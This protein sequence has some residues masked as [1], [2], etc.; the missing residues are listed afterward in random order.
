MN[1]G[2][3][4]GPYEVVGSLGAGG[5]G[6]VCRARDTRLNRDVALKVLPEAF[7]T[8]ADR[9]SRFEREAQL[10]AA[11]NHPN[12][13]AIYGLEE[14]GAHRAIVM[15]LVE[16]PTLADLVAL[17]PDRAELPPP[18]EAPARRSATEGRPPRPPSGS[19]GDASGGAPASVPAR[20]PRRA[21]PVGEALEIA[22]QIADAVSTRTTAG[23]S[24]AT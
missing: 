15:E 10:L 12:I 8:D 2:T 4:I 20:A 19:S 11:V 6:E 1:P 24:I 22:R 16:G 3:R 23:S 13:A 21:L 5:M 14:A 18:Q 7:A 9:M 17:A